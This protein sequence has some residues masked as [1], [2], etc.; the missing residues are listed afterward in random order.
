MGELIDARHRLFSERVPSRLWEE[1]LYSV[2]VYI[3]SARG[4]GLRRIS[5]ALSGVSWS[6]DGERLALV[7]TEGEEVALVTIARDGSDPEV[8]TRLT[9]EEVIGE[10]GEREPQAASPL[11][12]SGA[13][14]EG[15]SA[16]DTP[17]PSAADC[18]P[19]PREASQ[20][21]QDHRSVEETHRFGNSPVAGLTTAWM[22]AIWSANDLVCWRPG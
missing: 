8:I 18:Q 15:A 2:G 17:A 13:A 1:L 10:K 12:K 4:Y 22:A 3:R 5:R 20:A 21:Q 9:D 19:D 6:P 14:A 7:R 16:T 11:R